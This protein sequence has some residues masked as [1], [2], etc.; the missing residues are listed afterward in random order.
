M[1]VFEKKYNLYAA[2]IIIIL[3]FLCGW[4]A[5][6]YMHGGSDVIC[7]YDTIVKTVVVDRPSVYIKNAPAEIITKEKIKQVIDTLIVSDTIRAYDT[8]Y[9]VRPFIACLDTVLPSR[10]TLDAR[11][12]FPENM[13]DIF[14]K[15]KPDTIQTQWITKIEK[16]KETESVWVKIG[17]GS[18]GIILGYILGGNN[19]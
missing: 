19:K 4:L 13:F 2:A 8:A 18:A 7:T 3:A 15:P 10:D 1:R 12:Y 6:R 16:E 5:G 11:Y 17:I 14:F 9:L